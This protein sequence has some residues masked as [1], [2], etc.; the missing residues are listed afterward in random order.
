VKDIA[1]SRI[2]DGPGSRLQAALISELNLTLPGPQ[3]TLYSDEDLLGSFDPS[4]MAHR[5]TP[6][7][8]TRGTQRQN[9]QVVE[10]QRVKA[11]MAWR[12]FASAMLGGFALVTP[13]LIIVIGTSNVS[14]R[15]LIVVSVSIFLFALGVALFSTALPEN[16]LAATAA[17]AAVLVVFISN[18]AQPCS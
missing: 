12:R 2:D 7:V 10:T 6:G 17:Y 9:S 14:V 5:V 11:R 15:A 1:A 4:L 3:H 16:L 8:V 18:N 13:V